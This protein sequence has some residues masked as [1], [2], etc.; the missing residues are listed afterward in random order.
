M[1]DVRPQAARV[2]CLPKHVAA[3]LSGSSF[4][5]GKRR[6]ATT[7]EGQTLLC[8]LGS[9]LRG[10]ET[11]LTP[12]SIH[13]KGLPAGIH[14]K[15]RSSQGVELVGT[16]LLGWTLNR[17]SWATCEQRPKTL[18]RHAC[19]AGRVLSS[20]AFRLAGACAVSNVCS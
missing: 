11:V 13:R 18:S 2:I 5:T 17:A 19:S 10:V 3:C 12:T 7:T 14:L 8:R 15:A 16:R 4:H 1:E 6:C 9:G 20:C